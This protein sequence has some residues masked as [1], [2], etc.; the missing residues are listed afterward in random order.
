MVVTFVKYVISLFLQIFLAAIYYLN[1]IYFDPQVS[2]I[3]TRCYAQARYM[4]ACGV[5]PSVT[6]VYHVKT[7]NMSLKFFHHQVATPF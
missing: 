7:N 6:F 4:A 2:I 1:S 5:R 3:T